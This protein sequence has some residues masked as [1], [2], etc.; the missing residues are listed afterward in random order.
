MTSHGLAEPQW[1]APP[2]V[3]YFLGRA[4]ISLA[5]MPFM[6]KPVNPDL[7][8]PSIS[9]I[10]LP[11]DPY[12]LDPSLLQPFQG[13]V[14]DNQGQS[15][16]PLKVL[17]LDNLKPA[18]S[19]LSLL[20]PGNLHI[21]A[22]APVLPC[23]FSLLSTLAPPRVAPRGVLCSLFLRSLCVPE[24]PSVWKLCQHLCALPHPIHTNP[25]SLMPKELGFCC[26]EEPK[27]WVS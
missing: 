6:C 20:F 8:C 2:R 17:K 18:S 9:F 15:V 16:W 14:S 13:Q 1:T 22:P 23:S 19:A 4:K 10:R 11:Q 27:N 26:F 7:I 25:R 5:S 3:G 24:P 12:T 21:K